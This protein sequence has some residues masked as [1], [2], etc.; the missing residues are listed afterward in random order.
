MYTEAGMKLKDVIYQIIEEKIETYGYEVS[1]QDTRRIVAEISD[2][3]DFYQR[4]DTILEDAL[5]DTMNDLNIEEHPMSKED[6]D[7]LNEVIRKG[8]FIVAP[9]GD[10][11]AEPSC[12]L[13]EDF[14]AA[15]T[16]AEENSDVH[17]YTLIEAEGMGFIV[18]GARLVNR[19]AY[20]LSVDDAGI[21]EDEEV[22]FW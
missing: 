7:R 22:R 11:D 3:E 1:V 20:M 2:S 14:K 17:V 16:F 18:P 13:W 9:D 15:Q 8:Q 12:Y 4:L 19:F 6:E 21:D 10:P 5:H